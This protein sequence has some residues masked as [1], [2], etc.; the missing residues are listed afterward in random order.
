VLAG[1]GWRLR[2]LTGAGAGAAVIVG[3]FVFWGGGL[4]AAALLFLFVVSSSLLSSRQR[5]ATA[6]ARDA[7]QV[8]ANGGWAA[9]G[10][11]VVPHRAAVG[12]ALLV[13]ALATAQA[14]TWASEIGSHAV[15]PPRLITTRA[16][17]ARGTSGAVSLLGTAG[18]AL[19][20]LATAGLA[21]ALGTGPR[22][23]AAGLAAG[24]LGMLGDSLLG[25]TLQVRCRCRRCGA[26]CE[27]G[28]H[29]G[30]PAERVGGLSWLDN[31]GVNLA[32]TSAGA[33]AATALA[34]C[35]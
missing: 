8:L 16:P 24:I 28:A 20:A 21:L 18:G 13:G 22:V 35:C 34:R 12:W 2:W 4:R 6:F 26:A 30:L 7:R 23:A 25:A 15:R 10:A 29:C 31:D 27:R 14:D 33:L 17:V 19:G 1:A 5:N 3:G 11:M 9:V 32:A